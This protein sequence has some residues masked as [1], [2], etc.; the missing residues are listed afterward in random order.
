MLHCSVEYQSSLLCKTSQNKQYTLNVKYFTIQ[1]YVCYVWQQQGPPAI[2]EIQQV[3]KN[4]SLK[5]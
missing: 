4:D 5:L 2:N 3:L 1:M